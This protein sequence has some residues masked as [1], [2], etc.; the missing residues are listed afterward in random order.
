MVDGLMGIM[1]NYDRLSKEDSLGE[2]VL[3]PDWRNWIAHRTSNPGVVSSSLTIG[4]LFFK[5][6]LA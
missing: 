5:Y 6:C 2:P 3:K 4:A 1:I